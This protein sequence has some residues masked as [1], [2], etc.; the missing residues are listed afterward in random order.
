[1]TWRG[2]EVVAAFTTY[3]AFDYLHDGDFDAVLLSAAEDLNDSLSIS[4][5]MRRNTGCTTRPCC[6]TCPRGGR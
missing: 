5:G 2:A 6:S 4:A 1:M 3:T